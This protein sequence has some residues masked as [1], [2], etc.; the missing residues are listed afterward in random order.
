MSD[1]VV[2][3]EVQPFSARAALPWLVSLGV[4]ALLLIVGPRLLGDPDSYSHI[5]VGR[6]IIAHG[7]LPASDL[8]AR[9]RGSG[10]ISGGFAAI[11]L[12][13]LGQAIDLAHRQPQPGFAGLDASGRGDES[14]WLR[15]LHLLGQRRARSLKQLFD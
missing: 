1:Q 15:R 8:W 7:T 4:Y 9:R 10:R 3:S 14:L 11:F 5:E 13:R 12:L 6:W 2:H